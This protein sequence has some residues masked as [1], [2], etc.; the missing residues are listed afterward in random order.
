[1]RTAALSR[2]HARHRRRRFLRVC[3]PAFVVFIGIA[4]YGRSAATTM[5]VLMDLQFIKDSCW[6]HNDDIY[7]YSCR[8]SEAELWEHFGDYVTT[9]HADARGQQKVPLAMHTLLFRSLITLQD[10]DRTITSNKVIAPSRRIETH[11]PQHLQNRWW[12]GESTVNRLVRE[13]IHQFI[14][15]ETKGL[16]VLDVGCG[17]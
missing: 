14:G 13:V 11:V 12:M 2:I 8:R 3:I 7:E 15:N 5:H 1:M 9:L 4:M 10:V 17:V 6:S 16:K